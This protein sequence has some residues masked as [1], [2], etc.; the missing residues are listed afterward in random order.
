VSINTL[1]YSFSENYSE[2]ADWKNL[3]IPGKPLNENKLKNILIKIELP[4]EEYRDPC[5][6]FKTSEHSIEVYIEDEKIY[7]YGKYT[8]GVDSFENNG[9]PLHLITIPTEYMNKDLYIR[10]NASLLSSAGL[11]SKQSLEREAALSKAFF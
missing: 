6:L 8:K 11:V 3:K 10:M 9:S 1:Q 7:S 5:L 4:S 2:N